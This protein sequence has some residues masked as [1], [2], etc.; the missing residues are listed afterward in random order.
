[1]LTAPTPIPP[2]ATATGTA[3]TTSTPTTSAPPATVALGVQ[4]TETPMYVTRLS[5]TTVP[6][7]EVSVQLQNTGEDPHNLIVLRTS[8]NA[9]VARFP[10]Q[11]PE[12]T[13]EVQKVRFAA[14]TYRLSCTIVDSASHDEKGMNATLTVSSG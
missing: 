14:G 6:A 1:M 3:P 7:G 4:E 2:P 8:D 13:S 12:S 9:V 11:A 10:N 5:R